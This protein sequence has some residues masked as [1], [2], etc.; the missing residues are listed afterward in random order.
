MKTKVAR[1]L[2]FVSLIFFA[3]VRAQAESPLGPL[4]P[5]KLEVA[6]SNPDGSTYQATATPALN[7]DGSVTYTFST[8]QGGLSGFTGWYQP[9][10]D[11]FAAPNT[12]RFVGI[13]GDGSL[14][15]FTYRP[16]A[17]RGATPVIVSPYVDWAVNFSPGSPSVGFY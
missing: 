15:V 4:A 17:I 3:G 2:V 10:L 1:R 16:N 5:P 8:G 9:I 7:A 6:F 13:G 14:L 11:G 12:S